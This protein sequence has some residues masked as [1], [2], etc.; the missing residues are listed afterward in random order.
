MK[1][2]RKRAPRRAVT[3]IIEVVRSFSLKRNLE[4]HLGPAFRFESADHFCSAKK[5]TTAEEAERTSELLYAFCR[6]EVLKAA[7]SYEDELRNRERKQGA[8]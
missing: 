7:R 2:K 4:N 6:Q 8:A 3:Q 1:P 5:T